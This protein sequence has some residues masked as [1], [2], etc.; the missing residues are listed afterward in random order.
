M[1]PIKTKTRRIKFWLHLSSAYISRY[2]YY[3]L[4]IVIAVLLGS[5]GIFKLIPK[6]T[7]SNM[8]SIGY[9]GNYSIETIPTEVL[10]LATKSLI[11]VNESG[12]PQPSLASHWT[13]AEDGKTYVIF[14]RDNLI[15]HD[16]TQVDAK[17]ITIAIENVQI[18][19]LN[20]KAIEFRLPN[21]IASFPTALD[22][23]VFKA[24]SFYGTGEFRITGI[25]K[26]GNTI[27]KINLVPK[28]KGLPGV[29]IKF[30]QTE[31]QLQN[32]VKIGDVRY[33]SVASSKIFE[34]WPNLEVQKKIAENEIVTI[35]F[36]TKDPNLGSKELRQALNFAINRS[37]FDGTPAF[38]PNS[39]ASWAYNA[40]VKRYD[41]NSGKAKE[42]LVKSQ[43]QNPKITLSVV[44]G[45]KD[46]A[47]S[48]KKDWE[49]LGISV[50]I[51]EEKTIPQNFQALLADYKI[52]PDPDQYGFWHST[53]QKTNLTKF[54]DQKIDKLLEDGRS[55]QKEED[56]KTIYQ[57]FQRFLVEDSPTVFL[58]HPYKYQVVYKNLKPQVEKLPIE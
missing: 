46:V 9:V 31:E 42:L 4:V 55:S 29:E 50:E 20:N 28:V 5:Y 3:F 14:L 49:D 19:A 51:K 47:A 34:S 54:A 8:V 58:Y 43:V 22:K 24:K 11:T 36:N 2:K 1:Q 52:P 10:S 53:Q 7:R 6:I 30:Y 56:R 48:I 16:D 40:E 37:S 13:V 57:E 39:Q 33:A 41:Y 32:A 25:T 38:S 17:D 21:P 15:W 44:G 18:T 12:R 35:F 26:S 45:H 27:Q 23:P